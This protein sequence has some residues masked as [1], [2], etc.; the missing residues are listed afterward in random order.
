M[1]LDARNRRDCTFPRMLRMF[2]TFLSRDNILCSIDEIFTN[3][4]TTENNFEMDR[5]ITPRDK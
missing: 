1:L 2:S 5:P 4:A 3:V